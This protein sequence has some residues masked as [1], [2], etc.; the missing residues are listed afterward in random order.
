LVFSF[1]PFAVG[2]SKKNAAQAAF[3]LKNKNRG[4]LGT[5]PGRVIYLLTTR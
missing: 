5:H 4:T 1:L 3:F 2:Q